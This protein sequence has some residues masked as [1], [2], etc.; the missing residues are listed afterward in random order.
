MWALEPATVASRTE[1]SSSQM[2]TISDTRRT[3]TMA[4]LALV[5]AFVF[6]PLAIAFG[7]VA[8]K[9]IA[10]TGEGGSGLATA[11]LVLGIVFTV[12]SL[13]YVVGMVV[14]FAAA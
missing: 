4:I 3:N 5:F 2:T 6:S 8:R 13:L 7:V 10:R 9:Q 12:L 11:G 14:L 1:R